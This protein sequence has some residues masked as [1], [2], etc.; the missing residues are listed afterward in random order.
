M[1]IKTT[2]LRVIRTVTRS[3]GSGI[4]ESHWEV[5]R[6]GVIKWRTVAAFAFADEALDHA[7]KTA[8]V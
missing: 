3:A 1:K 5:Q 2:K 8:G 4:Q 7:R 6:K